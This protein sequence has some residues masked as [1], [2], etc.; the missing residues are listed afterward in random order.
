MAPSATPCNAP[1]VTFLRR[2]LRGVAARG[3]SRHNVR[4]VHSRRIVPLLLLVAACTAGGPAPDSDPT[5]GTRPPIYTTDAA[6]PPEVLPDAGPITR[7]NPDA[8]KDSSAE[9]VKDA[10]ALPDGSQPITGIVV[11]ELLISEV[12]FN[13]AGV[14]PD[15]EWIELHNTTTRTLNL[16][17]LLLVD[18]S[19]RVSVV[20]P[21]VT[22]GAGAYGVMV[23]KRAGGTV[24]AT[25]IIFEYGLVQPGVQM[26]NSASGVIQLKDGPTL[27]AECKYG[28][29]AVGGTA[30]SAQLKTL[31]L[32]GSQAAGGWCT[33]Q[34][35][36]SGSG[37]DRGTPGMASDCP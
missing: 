2:V 25:A 11:G 28:A 7:P 14:E 9:T 36:W 8:G 29:F 5:T 20:G 12:M 26:V 10:A 17:G 27:L 35:T 4:R 6:P 34:N 24:P 15:S 3:A 1:N 33:S 37:A 23:R 16:A 31:T 19:A 22:L 30:A 32:V 13:P 21:G 18:S